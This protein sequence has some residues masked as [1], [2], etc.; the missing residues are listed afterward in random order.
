MRSPPLVRFGRFNLLVE[1]SVLA[2]T[3][4]ILFLAIGFT[5]HEINRR[6]LE[7]RLTDAAKVNLFLES[8]LQEARRSLT[9]FAD[10][11]EAERSPAILTLF[12]AFA[13]L[14]RLDPQL[15]VARVYKATPD[16][17]V[18]TGF[19]FA[20]GKL[21]AYLHADPQGSDSSEIMHGYEDEAPSVYYALQQ[22]G[23][24]FLGR[25]NLDYVRALLA[26]FSHFSGTPVLLVARDG[27][28]MLASDPELRIPA[29]DLR[30][31]EGEPS[32]DRTLITNEQAWIPVISGTSTI[33]AHIVALI[34]TELLTSQRRALLAFA[35]LFTGVLV[36]LVFLKNRRLDRL[37]VQPLAAF[38]RKMG[39]LAV[40]RLPTPDEGR[41]HR[42]VELAEI[43]A[44]FRD[45][46]T[47][48][49]DREASLRASEH[50]AEAANR[51]KSV[52]LANMSHEIRTPL[53]A[54]LG[55]AQVLVR[56]ANLTDEQ[57][58]NLTTIRRSGEHLLTLI[59]DILD[60]AKIE[61]GRLTCQVT[62]FDLA[63]LLNE[64]T[65]LFAQQARDRGLD[66][67]LEMGPLP[68]LVAGDERKLR[69]VLINLLGNALK[70]TAA[71]EV[72]LRVE[73]SPS[74]GLR[75]S[76]SDTGPGIP[77]KDQTRIFQPFAQ[78]EAGRK[79]Q[80]GT[81]L[82]LALSSQFV[83]LMG[84]D[85]RVDSTPGQGSCFSF[86]LPLP[87]VDT[88]L[89]AGLPAPA[90]PQATPPAPALEPP[91]EM[92]LPLAHLSPSRVL[93]RLAALPPGWRAELEQA[94]DMG[95]FDRITRLVDQAREQNPVLAA[96]L[97][98]WAYD[99]NLEAFAQALAALGEGTR[100]D[101]DRP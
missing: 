14:Y 45:M 31:W 57:R 88:P 17:K 18:F 93:T 40:G 38:T 51:A 90:R 16:S 47:A 2:L 39:D 83:R 35:S 34:P 87:A 42:F 64:V 9:T 33:G 76:V 22:G 86:T 78:A 75:F 5:L 66:L 61:A 28:V 91:L 55:Y 96:A 46:A 53:N 101:E 25:L 12:A 23:Q 3:S 11:P 73:A 62:P 92:P 80:G 99:Y 26:Q 4:G 43:H 79:T 50:R 63:R 68:G 94:V 27:F 81:G 54:I 52:F 69:Q 98:T 29:V 100:P 19:S 60:L 6:Y 24:R 8:Q 20:G 49:R 10:L 13:D 7:L 30:K 85:L 82:G 56:D 15:R 74:E 97:G 84:G 59:N 89:P 70:F 48:I 65:A 36:L 41:N 44:G 77:L 71:G 21:G 58:R 32:P 1:V 67:R 95:D 72:A 37:V